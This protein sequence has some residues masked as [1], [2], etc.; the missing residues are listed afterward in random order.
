MRL[1]LRR[2]SEARGLLLAA[3]AAALVAI[4]MITGLMVYNGQA[5]DAGKRSVVRSAPAEERS[6]LISGPIGAGPDVY[7]ER[8]AAVRDAF[9]AGLGGLPVTVAGVRTGTGRQLTGDLGEFTPPKGQLIFASL[10]TLDDLPDHADLG[11]GA[12][13]QA[14]GQPLQV[15]LPERIAGKLGVGVGDRIPLTDRATDRRSEVIVVG[16]WQPRDP[17]GAY[18]RLTP[19]I[20]DDSATTIGPFVLA[21]ADF[22]RV[23]P[24]GTSAAWL[25]EPAL[26]TAEAAQLVDAGRD[27]DAIAARLPGQVGLGPSGQVVT[28]LDRLADRLSRADLVGRST[29]LTPV[30][31]IVVLGGYALVLVA[32][33][34]AEDRR[35]Q[36]AL[37]RAR[38]AARR[39]LAGL[40]VREAAMVIVPVAVVAP[41]LVSQALRY[42]DRSSWLAELG[43]EPRLTVYTW[44]VAAVVAAGCL[45]ALVGPAL[46]RGG[47]YIEDLGARSRPGRWAA[48]QRAGVDVALVG[49]AVL[50]WAQLRQ[51]SS[52]LAGAT[53]DVDP[54]LAAAPTLGVLGGAVIALRLLPPATRFAE[55]FVTDRPW[56]ATMLGMWQA[57]RRP[58]AGPVLLLALA[59]GGGTVAWSLV[60]T[61]QSSLVDQANHRVGAD[62]RVTE[63]E[64]FAPAERAAQL[65]ALPGVR[66]V[67]PTWHEEIRIGGDDL[68]AAVVA[69][70]TAAAKGVIQLRDDLVDGSPDDLL[71]RLA[72]IRVTA[73][74]KDLPADARRLSGTISTPAPNAAIPRDATTELLL[75]TPDGQVYRIPLVTT[76][77][78]GR[79]VPFTVDL[80]DSGGRPLR[81]AGFRVDMLLSDTHTYGFKVSDLRISREDGTEAPADLG[82]ERWGIVDGER[83]TPTKA[84]SAT[85]ISATYTYPYPIGSFFLG[86]PR[87]GLTLVREH[88]AGPVPAAVTPRVLDELSARVGQTIPLTLPGGSVEITIVDVVDAVPTVDGT[89]AAILLDL[90][91]AATSLLHRAGYVAPVPQW[92]IGTEPGWHAAAAQAAG[93]LSGVTVLDRV[94]AAADAGHDPYWLGA[95]TG[96]LVAAVGAVLLAVVGLGVDV[97]AT[98]RRRVGEL[99]VLHTLGAAPRLLARA[100]IAEQAFLAGVG[101]SVGLVVSIGVGA[102]MAPLVILTPSADR[103]VPAPVLDL[104]WGAI[105]ATAIGLLA[106]AV[107][108]S[109][110]IA[111]TIRQ[112]VAAAQ[113]RIGADR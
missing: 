42:A 3:A 78:D 70:D 86:A 26:A 38:G 62:L 89:T 39:Q 37:L 50:A 58:H 82:T 99:A 84:I 105:G 20:F 100:L 49:L 10:V 108:L 29:L 55:R 79:S 8:D 68:P 102:S 45:L 2:A 24:G 56:T 111:V 22:P 47:T 107:L 25:V 88:V 52:P 113:L 60:T 61:W 87:L 110:F 83:S 72:A 81:I 74:G 57:G 85:G 103:P 93:H 97:W 36:I 106:V 35:P 44:L 51:Y 92:W 109:G 41:P 77:T 67:L 73:P 15:V 7:A 14:G 30:L 17:A 28:R 101:V 59:V 34:L 96:L 63:R 104:D 23:F 90:P 18:W 54:L 69:L 33:L 5:I 16:L 40:A 64:W 91:S 112:R 98:A 75:S 19:Q 11:A 31:L 53:T 32:A 65:A 9:A 48:A 71:D 21:A 43:L 94:T 4:A 6:L 66:A 1:V 12:W 80:P 27:A 95:R 46:R 76:G 13:P